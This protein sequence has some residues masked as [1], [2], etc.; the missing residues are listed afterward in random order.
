MRV[1]EDG[2]V[3]STRCELTTKPSFVNRLICQ[4]ADVPTEP[5]GLR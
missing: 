2:I 5:A 4:V 3:D 1:I